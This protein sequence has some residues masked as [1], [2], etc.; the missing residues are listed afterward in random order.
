LSEPDGRAALIDLIARR[1]VM[2]PASVVGAPGVRRRLPFRAALAA[3]AVIAALVGGFWLGER[4]G[5]LAQTA[6]PAATRVIET[7]EWQPLP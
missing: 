2:K 1:H 3:A 7:G 6:A 4:R 5:Q